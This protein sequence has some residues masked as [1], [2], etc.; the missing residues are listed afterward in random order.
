[1]PIELE[2]LNNEL[3]T[4]EQFRKDALAAI[5][6]NET[7][8]TTITEGLKSS[9]FEVMDQKAK[10]E[11]LERHKEEVF[12]KELP[13]KVREIHDQY[14]TTLKKFGIERQQDEKTYAALER[15]LND[16]KTNIETL[17]TQ[18]GGDEALKAKIAE[19]ENNAKTTIA[20]KD[21]ALSDLQSKYATTEK[22][23]QLDKVFNPIRAKFKKDLPDY[24]KSHEDSV[25][26]SVLSKSVVEGDVMYMADDN[27][28]I[29]K[30][31]S[32]NP[33]KVEDYLNEQ[34]KTVFADVNK[35][36]GG[37]GAGGDDPNTSSDPSD[38]KVET[39]VL[40]GNVKNKGE[41]ATYLAS[42]GLIQNTKNYRDI[43]GKFG[44][45]LPM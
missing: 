3:Q 12:S 43:W 21:K 22:K 27:G 9:G 4:N 44:V 37:A 40:P 30:D 20:E 24:F 13:S 2:D 25:I 28:N 38:I 45:S 23:I 35:P 19:I 16:Y 34:F 7:Y 15:G 42:K 5:V 36:A 8:R 17:K 29:L 10:S 1:M 31:G 41:L 26:N 11:L 14:D 18:S 32:Y 33:I 6:G 39:F